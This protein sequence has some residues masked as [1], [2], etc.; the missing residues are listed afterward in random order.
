MRKARRILPIVHPALAIL[1]L[2]AVAGHAGKPAPGWPTEVQVTGGIK[3]LDDGTGYPTTGVR[4]EFIDTSLRIGYPDATYTTGQVFISNPDHSYWL[5]PDDDTPSLSVTGTN[6]N[7]TLAYFYCAHKD[8]EVTAELMCKSSAAHADYYY[9]LVILGG[10]VQ[11]TGAVLF[12]TGSG[13]M[14][15][16]KTPEP[17]STVAQ[18]RLGAAVTYKVIP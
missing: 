6:A 7:K 17:G 12:P 8:H 15:N 1:G 5:P 16:K 9:C 3:I 14:I 13:W 2:L 11:K 18:G 10:K 4:V